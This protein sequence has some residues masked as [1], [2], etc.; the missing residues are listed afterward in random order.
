MIRAKMEV[1]ELRDYGHSA[2][3]VVLSAR[4]D[5][6][7]PEDQRFAEATPNGRIEMYVD[8]PAALEQLIIGRVFYLDFT[9]LA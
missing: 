9:P 6:S 8:N 1:T 4:Y 3:T 5:T 7:I 2:R